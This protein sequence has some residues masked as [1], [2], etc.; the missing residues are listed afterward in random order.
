MNAGTYTI[1]RLEPVVH[2]SNYFPTNNYRVESTKFVSAVALTSQ[3]TAWDAAKIVVSETSTLSI[4]Q[5]CAAKDVVW[6]K[7]ITGISEQ[8]G[9][10]GGRGGEKKKRTRG[11][12]QSSTLLLSP[13]LIFSDSSSPSNKINILS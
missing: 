13:L 10:G 11:E 6:R 7:V 9:G 4:L 2:Y 3:I 12:S 5:I 8:G 1:H